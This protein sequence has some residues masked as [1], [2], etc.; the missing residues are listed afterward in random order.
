MKR[1]DVPLT[2]KCSYLNPEVNCV[3]LLKGV[4]LLEAIYLPFKWKSIEL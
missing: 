3:V 4:N 2:C 1:G